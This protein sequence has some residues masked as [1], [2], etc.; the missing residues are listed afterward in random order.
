MFSQVLFR[1][2]SI[3]FDAQQVVR[4]PDSRFDPTVHRFLP[5]SFLLQITAGNRVFIRIYFPVLIPA[6]EQW[7]EVV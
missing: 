4:I 3:W 2:A 5:F 6:H 1:R 7:S